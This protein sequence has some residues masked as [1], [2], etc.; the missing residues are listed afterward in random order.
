MGG[1]F[2]KNRKK[3]AGE[4]SF[5][6]FGSRPSRP[7][8]NALT[9]FSMPGGRNYHRQKAR[10]EAKKE[11]KAQLRAAG[12]WKTE[13]GRAEQARRKEE[14]SQDQPPGGHGWKHVLKERS[15][16]MNKEHQ[17][18]GLMVES[19]KLWNAAK[20]SIKDHRLNRTEKKTY[21]PSYEVN[22]NPP[23]DCLAKGAIT[24]TCKMG[25]VE[26]NGTGSVLRFAENNAAKKMLDLLDSEAH[27]E[28]AQDE[29]TPASS[30][31]DQTPASS[32]K[33]QI[34]AS[35]ENIQTP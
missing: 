28:K 1:K 3:D 11:E 15:C 30:G 4:K 25:E 16:K 12:L 29:E 21:K 33:N 26:V 9:S 10:N 23:P 20:L 8:P 17:K 18:V 6:S 35:S 19:K 14:Q 24:V 27:P 22:P 7:R 32:G 13:E 2:G 34:P 31:K 5:G